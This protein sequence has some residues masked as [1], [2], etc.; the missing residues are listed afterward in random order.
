MILPENSAILRNRALEFQAVACPNFAIV[1][2]SPWL[3]RQGSNRE[4]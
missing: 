4:E 1:E 3:L 2:T